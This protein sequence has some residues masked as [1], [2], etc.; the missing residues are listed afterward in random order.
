MI[1]H[2]QP[3]HAEALTRITIAAKRHWNYP[4]H[5]IQQWLPLLTIHPNY[6]ALNETW[7]AMIQDEPAAYYSLKQDKELWLDNLW[8]H[9]SYMGKGVGSK[10]FTHAL[11]RCR[12]R[13][14]SKLKIEADPHAQPFYERMGARKVSEHHSEMDGQPRFLPVMEIDV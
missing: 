3:I 6:I 8:V 10:L 5:W 13:G 2:A 11:E 14:A 1:V 9:P 4:E 12:K 7:M